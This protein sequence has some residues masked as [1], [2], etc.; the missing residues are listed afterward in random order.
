MFKRQSVMRFV[1]A[2]MLQAEHE[3]QSRRKA[4]GIDNIKKDEH[5]AN[6]TKNLTNLLEWIRCQ[7]PPIDP[8]ILKCSRC[9][10]DLNLY[11]N[12][13][14]PIPYLHHSKLR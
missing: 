8:D 5:D 12:P 2:E 7:P 9:L 1:N 14:S 10:H 3:K 11:N 4:T 13:E 6:I